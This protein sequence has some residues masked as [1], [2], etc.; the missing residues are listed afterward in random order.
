[1]M[2][3]SYSP[4]RPGEPA[5]R[6]SRLGYHVPVNARAASWFSSLTLRR[7]LALAVAAGLLLGNLALHKHIEKVCAAL[8]E[9]HGFASY[10]RAMFWGLALASGAGLIVAALRLRSWPRSLQSGALVGLLGALTYVSCRMLMMTAVE[11]VHFPQFALVAGAL[12]A[13]GV[14]IR[15]AWTVA[16]LGGIADEVYQR[17]TL[18]WDRPYAYL[19]FNDM[20][21]DAIG[22]AWAVM[23]VALGRG[24]AL[25][26]DP[27]AGGPGRSARRRLWVMIGLGTLLFAA[28]LLIDLYYTGSPVDTAPFGRD[29]R[30]LSFGE[31]ALLFSLV[32]AIVWQLPTRPG[33]RGQQP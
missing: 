27:G 11:L 15:S 22:A 25:P 18:Y 30:R 6:D 10:D 13:G 19:D 21:L 23:L 1:M 2:L 32:G 3:R 8:A 20:I 7:R 33:R 5:R 14:G 12:L 28:L 17:L 16:A 31:G 26:D 29:Y 24:Y 9:R 4:W